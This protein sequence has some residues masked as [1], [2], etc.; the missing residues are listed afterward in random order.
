MNNVCGLRL[1]FA[2]VIR[3]EMPNSLKALNNIVGKAKG[4]LD[5]EVVSLRVDE[6]T[7][8]Y[9]LS[10]DMDVYS[11]GVVVDVAQLGLSIAD[12]AV[13]EL[14]RMRADEYNDLP[15]TQDAFSVAVDQF[16]DDSVVIVEAIPRECVIF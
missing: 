12:D 14:M 1:A 15:I 7:V 10:V 13:A 9:D 8:I 16:G 2:D 5:Q 3:L 4:V 11:D 6:D